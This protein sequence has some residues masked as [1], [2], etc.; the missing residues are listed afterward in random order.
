MACQP[1]CLS[2]N[3][4]LRISC[5]VQHHLCTQG[6]HPPSPSLVAVITTIPCQLPKES[7][8]QSNAILALCSAQKVRNY[9]HAERISWWGCTTCS[10]LRGLKEIHEEPVSA[11][12]IFVLLA[13]NRLRCENLHCVVIKKCHFF[14]KAQILKF[15]SVPS[16][17]IY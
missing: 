16:F 1:H 14:I 15:R 9:V 13:P 10:L 8:L 7:S 4:Y 11:K 17:L 6:V 12:Y 2:R 3:S 5:L